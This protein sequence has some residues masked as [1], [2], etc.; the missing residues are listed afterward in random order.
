MEV[1]ADSA[2]G[3]WGRFSVQDVGKAPEQPGLY[4]WYGKLDVG[5]ADWAE[6]LVDGEDLG[7]RLL[8]DVLRRHT[9]RFQNR[10]LHAEVS[11]SSFRMKWTGELSD[12][13]TPEL[14][15]LLTDRLPAGQ[16]PDDRRLLPQALE[17]AKLRE[18]LVTTLQITSPILSSPLYIGVSDN[19]RRRLGDHVRALYR[20][21]RSDDR[22]CD[23]EPDQ[24]DDFAS[25]AHDQGFTDATLEVFTFNLGELLS[26]DLRGEQ[27]Q[28]VRLAAEFIL[29]RWHRPVLGKK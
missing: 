15:E 2:N 13:T 28:A 20:L 17:H 27:L 3:F 18:A 4:A 29:N 11:S 23:L 25:R 6:H 7:A 22:S 1:I 5:P 19:L 8:R 14:A 12:V 26:T 16:S 24:R 21:M 9:T 10:G